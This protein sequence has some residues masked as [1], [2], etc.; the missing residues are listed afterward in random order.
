[1][2]AAW[3]DHDRINIILKS[4]SG[5]L[6]VVDRTGAVLWANERYAALLD[7]PAAELEGK[8]LWEVAD[9]S[10]M[11]LVLSTG[12]TVIKVMGN[13]F[14]QP[15]VLEEKPLRDDTEIIGGIGTVISRENR[16]VN[17]LLDKVSLLEEELSYYRERL[18]AQVPGSSPFKHFISGSEKLR[19]T[20]ELAKRT[21]RFAVGILITGERGTGKGLLAEAI[22]YASPRKKHPFVRFNCAAVPP[23]LLEAELF[24]R[25]DGAG[26][27]PG[28]LE[29]AHWGTLLLKDV[30]ELTLA[31]QA[32]LLRAVQDG[33]LE[34]LGGTRPVK[35]DV[36]VIAT[37]SKDLAEQVKRGKFR[38]DLYYRLLAVGLHMPPLRER[39]E[40]L[41]YLTGSILERLSHNYGL[42]KP[43]LTER[44]YE[45][46]RNYH[47]P[48]N[49]RELETVLERALHLAE[50]GVIDRD[51]LPPDLVEQAAVENTVQ[52]PPLDEVVARREREYIQEVLRFTDGNRQKAAEILGLS[53][54]AL[55]NKLKKYGIE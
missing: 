16:A 20:V 23:A 1:M 26:G 18:A 40:D 49:V 39:L 29:L 45:I 36:R 12:E 9:F 51:H 44:A 34:R 17:M 19:H 38:E 21:A 5:G 33:E 27:R 50:A 24:G 4:I 53:R 11:N 10:L 7:M 37:T 41:A 3:F 25:E 8:T 14:G 6:V 32:R 2:A 35:I 47:W 31:A 13:R 42:S 43:V 15:V 55:Y 54:T 46:M 30:E 28:K 22:H 48:G 52:L